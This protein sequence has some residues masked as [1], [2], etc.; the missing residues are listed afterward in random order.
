M[1][2]AGFQATQQVD[3]HMQIQGLYASIYVADL[4]VAE[5]FYTRLLGRGPDD[6]PLE[7]MVQWRGIG[8]AGIQLFLDK[9]HA[10][11]GVMTIVTP[12]IEAT[13]TALKAKSIDLG[14]IR[15]GGYGA[16]ANLQDPDSNRLNIAEPPKGF[17]G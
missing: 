13:K 11:H 6:R 17:K 10:G 5:D 8:T 7:T 16:I 1:S 14:E 15:R 3:E 9:G 2:H 4:K 12:D